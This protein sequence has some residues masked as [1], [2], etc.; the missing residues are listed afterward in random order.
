M[1]NFSKN[2]FFDFCDAY[3]F[4]REDRTETGGVPFCR[5]LANLEF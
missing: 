3:N 4:L 2:A 1:R 5:E